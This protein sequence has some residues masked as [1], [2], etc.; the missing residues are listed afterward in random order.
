MEIGA[1]NDLDFP[2]SGAR[3]DVG[4][5]RSLISGIG[6]YALNEWKSAPRFMQQ[7]ASAVA[8]LD[9]GGQNTH[10]EE[11][12]ERVDEDMALTARDLLARVKT[13]RVEHRA[14]F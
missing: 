1:F 7:G 5:F 8:V 10:A 6:E 2:A 11:K 4:H 14:P 12:A 9:I 13:L 3:H